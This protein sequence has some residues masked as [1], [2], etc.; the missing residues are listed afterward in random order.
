MSPIL[1]A[2]PRTTLRRKAR[3]RP[4]TPGLRPRREVEALLRELAFA[5]HL[6]RSV[7]ESI[8]AHE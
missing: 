8:A 7:K 3:R 2:S 1:S 4:T 5:L 6:A